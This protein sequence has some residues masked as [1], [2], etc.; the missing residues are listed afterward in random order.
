[1]A[2]ASPTAAAAAG[3][4]AAFLELGLIVAGLAVLGRLAARM[5]VSPIPFYLLGGLAFGKGGLAPLEV[6]D[7]FLEI[8]ANVGVILLLFTLGL[9]YTSEELGTSLRT[10]WRAG[11]VD[12]ALN[13]LPGLAMGL[14]LG[15]SPMVALLLAGVTLVSSSG[16]IAKMLADLEWL[17]NRETPTVLSILVLEDL[18]M[19]VY[20]P[21]VAVLLVGRS[22][23]AGLAAV[24]IAVVAAA[25]AL[26][27][28]LRYG[29]HLTRIM[30]HG[31]NEVLLLSA[32]GLV[33]LVAAAAER[34][35][36]SAAVGAFLV[37]VALTG[38]VAEQLR[39]LLG[40]LRDLF[41]AIFFVF[42]GL[43]IDP[44]SIPPVLGLAA[45][46]GV[47]SSATK[48]AT[49]WWAA[50]R[51]GVGVRGRARAGTALIARGEFSIVLA[52]MGVT[53]G[54]EPRL[55]PLAAAYVLLTAVAGPILARWSDPVV[56]AVQAWRARRA[57]DR[58]MAASG[59]TG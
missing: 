13:L 53:A 24:S 5:R 47:V 8:G 17:G 20:L 38:P 55:G 4:G 14:L 54:V 6:T 51:A 10:G 40:P 12:V 9:E 44:A 32:L 56:A 43:E 21:V 46:L 3:P 48:I 31:S 39:L 15:W 35:Q 27:F 59:A 42:F 37:G 2:E 52:G 7:R 45:V 23:G 50:T 41:A 33:L 29:G 19:A 11:A 36:V 57:G 25:I 49:G 16:I 1:M 28:A 34:L 18:V 58:T 30:A 26:L 22:L